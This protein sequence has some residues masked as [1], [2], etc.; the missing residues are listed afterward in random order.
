MLAV[1]RSHQLEG[2]VAKRLDSPY[3]SGRRNGAWLKHKHRRRET[4]EVTG[5][6]PA[7][8]HARRPDSIF[9]ARTLSDGTLIPAGSAELGLSAGERDQLRTALAARY[10]ETRRGSHRVARGIWVDIDY[11]GDRSGSPRDA[12]MRV[13]RIEA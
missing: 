7:T 4:F 11:H 1:T 13:L 10:L 12:V 3:E 5:W 6:R 9:I 8:P 2:I